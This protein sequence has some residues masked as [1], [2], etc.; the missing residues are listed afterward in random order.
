M[1]SL[2]AAA[3]RQRILVVILSGVLLVAGLF[4]YA[5]LNIEAYPDPVPPLVDIITQNP[6]QSSEEIERY[7]TIPIEI[8]MAGLPYIQAIR[9]V[10]LF[11]LSD[12]KVQFTYDVTYQQASQMVINRLSQL[13]PL[14]NGAQPVLSPT[15]PIGEVFRYRVA[16]PPGYSSADL[17]TVQDWILQRRFK[18]IPGVID[19]TGWGGRTKTYDITVDL[20][21]LMAYGLTLKQV[22]DGLNNANINVGANTVNIGSQSAIVRSVGQIRS[23]DDIR[24]TML[25]VRDGAPVL[26]SDVATVTVG[27]Q[28]RLGI[29]GQ[30]DDNDIIQGIVLMRRG[31]ETM[32]TLTGVLDEVDKINNGNILPPGVRIERIYDRSALVEVTT[33]TVLH[34]MVMGVV[35][36]FLI[37]WLFL[38]DL[39]SAL[40]VSA[41]IPFALLFAVVILVLSGESANLLSMGAIDFGII[42]DATVIMVE[43]IFRHLAQASHGP[44][45][46]YRRPTP[47]GLTGKLATIFHASSEVTQAIFFS[48][49]I[50]IAGFLPL[51]TL[52][53]V[54][55][56]IFGPMARTYAYA[57]LGGLIATFTVSPA[58]AALLLPDKVA[59][60]ETRAVRMLSHGY[61]RL[62]DVA[63][64]SRRVTLAAGLGAG[65]LAVLA[66]STI[67]LEFLP[68]LEEG[69]M[70]IRAVM[71]AS[72]S[73]EAG[74]DYANRMR[75]LI[76]S[77]PE[78]ETVISQHGRPDDGTDSTGFFNAE[79]FVPLK[80]LDRW[81]K[82]VDKDALI[83]EIN[84]ALQKA[85]PG[86]EFTF[87]QY[88]QDN[89]Q[90]AA[91]GVKGEN[92][93]KISGNDLETLAKLGTEIKNV[94]ATVPGITDLAV[95]A[96]LGQPTIRIDIDRTRAA[97]YGL[98]PGDINA[99]VQAAIG[100]QT[101]GDV[102]EGGSDRH[103]PMVVRL[104]PKYRQNLEAIKSIQI[105][106]Q[107][108]NGVT[109]VPLSEVAKVELVSG[110]YYI[111]RE[112]QERY[113]PVKFSVRG[114]DLGSAILE[115]Q[116]KVAEQVKILGGYRIEWVGEFGNLKNAL[117]RLAVAVPIAIGLIGL[118]LYMSFGSFRDTLLA[119]SAIPMALIGG[120]L[121]LF[122]VGM[123]FSISA[124]IG[125]VA[126]F[127]IAAMN[128]IMVLS[129]FNRL[130]DAGRDREAALRETCSVQLRPVLM[131]CAAAA[132]GLLPAAFSTAIGS[133]V[134]RP[135]ATVVVGGTL[136][137]PLLFLTV[138]PAAIG[139]FSR[140]HLPAPS[141]APQ[142]SAAEAS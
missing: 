88:I 81:R 74:N 50:I 43:N 82:G 2:I 41:T 78:A 101:A 108:G 73:L 142:A 33:H 22:L 6:G 19:V 72:I 133:Q 112:Q 9:T 116:Q 113:V 62:R 64:A 76:K 136:L 75:K 96:S 42:V 100:G 127:G 123:P 131:T 122:V 46:S 21:R 114:R 79:F 121:G 60:A 24:N 80:P 89:V 91:S 18:A 28:P 137:A 125:F 59:H 119:A 67:G 129:C 14:P 57:L 115:A 47:E 45:V 13:G 106:V 51:F 56:H 36:I 85:F 55:G 65:A 87:S 16:G 5:R 128:G 44:A 93:V 126:L 11:G 15:S 130:I 23:M 54:E 3:L 140:R 102:Y 84:D 117:Q 7:I 134:Q 32:P 141:E 83:A 68:K 35:L 1:Q 52:S 109:Q 104:A 103:F 90:E 118:L 86:V 12:V 70:W 95:S 110:A 120:V 17:K 53:G 34:N 98:A 49:T 40:I 97:R 29:A 39:R 30:N 25:T 94:L 10:S 124:A 111:Y 63:L 132:V 38:G 27:N 20:D 66:G 71:P 8:Q 69:N 31:A 26:V 77:F 135:L 61:A 139:L 4:A 107:I 48:A 138:L 99:T 92:S 37:Q 58:L 105:G